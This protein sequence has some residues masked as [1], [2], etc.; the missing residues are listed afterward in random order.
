MCCQCEKGV[1]LLWFTSTRLCF[2]VSVS[3]PI[4]PE[5]LTWED[6]AT[7]LLLML[8]GFF[9]FVLMLFLDLNYWFHSNSS[10]SN[11]CMTCQFHLSLVI[12]KYIVLNRTISALSHTSCT[13]V[14]AHCVTLNYR[15]VNCRQF[16]DYHTALL[17]ITKWRMGENE[18]NAPYGRLWFQLSIDLLRFFLHVS[19]RP[20]W[21]L[22][23]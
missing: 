6:N 3:P 7:R 22:E 23:R 5:S 8:M 17:L 2:L 16:W 18:N 14:V 19:V 20:L 4:R 15:H 11:C 13:N 10:Y 21:T 9:F 12:S 1:T